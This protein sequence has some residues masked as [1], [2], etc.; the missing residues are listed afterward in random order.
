MTQDEGRNVGQ[1]W[2]AASFAQ[3]S[4]AWDEGS[5]VDQ[6]ATEQG[7]G[8]QGP[9]TNYISYYPRQPRL[10]ACRNCLIY[11]ATCQP[12]CEMT[13]EVPASQKCPQE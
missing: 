11:T 5:C 4:I 6:E 8:K 2:L 10:A 1:V 12:G 3:K 9:A 7:P 13:A